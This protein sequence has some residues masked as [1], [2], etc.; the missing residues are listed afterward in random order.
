M[1]FHTE[2]NDTNSNQGNRVEFKWSNILM[3]AESFGANAAVLRA[4]NSYRCQSN[5]A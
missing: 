4:N 1:P 3:I 5:A 2:L